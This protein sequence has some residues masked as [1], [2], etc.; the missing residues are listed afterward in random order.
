MNFSN[1][2]STALYVS[3]VCIRTITVQSCKVKCLKLFLEINFKKKLN[4]PLL[5][6]MET[7]IRRRNGSLKH[8]SVDK[9][10][11]DVKDLIE[12][13]PKE[14]KRLQLVHD[15]DDSEPVKGK[16]KLKESEESL[17]KSNKSL[18][19]EVAK[20]T[21]QLVERLQHLSQGFEFNLTLTLEHDL[22]TTVLFVVAFVTRTYKLWLP[23]NV[24]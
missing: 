16:Q 13:S 6:I 12:E 5:F 23:N 19:P 7:K 10:D 24:V 9:S 4:F 3:V 22:I 11:G 1:F 2:L 18:T 20:S 21:N 8:N 14:N 17:K 15:D